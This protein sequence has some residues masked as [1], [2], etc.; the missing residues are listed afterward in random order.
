MITSHLISK[1]KLNHPEAINRSLH[2][3]IPFH[4][5]NKQKMNFFLFSSTL[6]IPFASAWGWPRTQSAS[7]ECSNEA[8]G[9][10]GAAERSGSS[11]SGA[12][13]SMPSSA[14]SCPT[15]TSMPSSMPSASTCPKQLMWN[16]SSSALNES[17]C[18][19]SMLYQS[20][21]LTNVTAVYQPGSWEPEHQRIQEFC[22]ERG[23]GSFCYKPQ[24]GSS[25]ESCLSMAVLRCPEGIL[26]SCRA[27]F[28]CG[29]IYSKQNVTCTWKRLNEMLRDKPWS[30]KSMSSSASSAPSDMISEKSDYCPAYK[31]YNAS[32]FNFT[33][34]GQAACWSISDVLK[35]PEPVN[36]TTT[37]D[38]QNMT[39]TVGKQEFGYPFATST[40]VDCTMT[41]VTSL[42][43]GLPQPSDPSAMICYNPTLQYDQLIPKSTC[44]G[45]Y[46]PGPMTTVTVCPSESMTMTSAS[47]TTETMTGAMSTSEMSSS[48]TIMPSS[49]SASASICPTPEPEPSATTSASI[50]TTQPV[51]MYNDYGQ[52]QQERGNVQSDYY[53]DHGNYDYG[54]DANDNDASYYGEGQGDH[55][56][57]Q[58]Y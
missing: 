53:P 56:Y 12:S 4:Q 52:G 10:A 13:A 43:S 32:L 7:G 8:S 34:S 6:L 9:A 47:E 38:A 19:D 5:A 57:G 37:T 44:A 23:N 51:M 40:T 14:G 2:T 29:E 27:G 1:E 46:P 11:G 36:L 45:P 31:Y 21:N 54:D 24:S 30:E 50:I 35:L 58:K 15:S 20:L 55:G 42:P 3:H 39:I 25:S 17:V 28:M 33:E 49:S 16:M 22:A 18:W 41:C 26:S 48:E